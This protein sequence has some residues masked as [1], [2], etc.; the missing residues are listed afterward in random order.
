MNEPCAETVTVSLAELHHTGSGLI[1][2]RCERWL[3][4]VTPSGAHK[5]VFVHSG[6]PIFWRTKEV[7]S[8]NYRLVH[9]FDSAT[10]EHVYVIHEAFYDE[11]SDTPHSISTTASWPQGETVEELQRDC[12]MYLQALSKP[13]LEYADF[14]KEP[15]RPDR[16][17]MGEAGAGVLDEEHLERVRAAREEREA[18]EARQTVQPVSA[19]G[20]KPQTPQDL[21]P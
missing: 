3:M 19:C 21:V 17:V 18:I 20:E 1:C 13:V 7:M 16:P 15:D 8:W 5:R 6:K 11:G 10:E 9:Q 12:E 4:E 2:A 14:D